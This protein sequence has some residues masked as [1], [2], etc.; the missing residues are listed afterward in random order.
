MRNPKSGL[1][2]FH[3]TP[4]LLVDF[5]P[6][7][8]ILVECLLARRFSLSMLLV[9]SG[10]PPT[11]VGIGLKIMSKLTD[12]EPSCSGVPSGSG[13][14]SITRDSSGSSHN[15]PELG[16]VTGCSLARATKKLSDL[17]LGKLG[18]TNMARKAAS[19]A[20]RRSSD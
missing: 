1:L 5:F 14:Q 3:E 7:Q 20:A 6:L 9:I 19:Q 18:R 2:F 17:V 13:N 8:K 4:A 12:I 10:H 11:C 15:R 16:A